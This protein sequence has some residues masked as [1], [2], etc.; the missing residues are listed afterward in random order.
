MNSSLAIAKKPELSVRSG[1]MLREH[2]QHVLICAIESALEVANRGQ[3]HSWMRGP[4]RMLLP[5]ESTACLE[6]DEHGGI[7]QLICLHHHLVDAVTMELLDNPEH[8]LAACLA[9]TYRGD[10]RQSCMV[11]ANALKALLAK[12][13]ALCDPGL[14]H[15]AVIHRIKL[16]SGPAFYVVLINVAQDQVER[17]RHILKLLSSHLKMA[18]SQAIAGQ[19]QRPGGPLTARELEVLRWMGEG[20]SNRE[21]STILDISALTLKNHVTKLYRK[22]DV[23]SREEAVARGLTSHASPPLD[24]V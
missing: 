10:R 9:R 14:L 23:Q 22:L 4:F 21:I 7:R 6:L 16:L 12:D 11:N 1:F 8:G 18:L 24:T 5:H 13:S 15:N 17:C 2:E 20:K 19:E 3:F